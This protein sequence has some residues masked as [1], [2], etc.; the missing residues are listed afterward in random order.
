[1]L[2]TRKTILKDV[3]DRYPKSEGILNKTVRGL[4][5]ITP[6]FAEGENKPETNNGTPKEGE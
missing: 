3:V 5:T 1:M 6:R 2:N 4:T